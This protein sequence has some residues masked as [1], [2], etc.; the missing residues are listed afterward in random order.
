[1]PVPSEIQASKAM[2]YSNIQP[3]LVISDWTVR[4]RCGI[5]VR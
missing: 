5:R 4:P 2:H 1:M 3:A